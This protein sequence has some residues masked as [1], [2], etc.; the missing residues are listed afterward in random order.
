[1]N[2]R[3]R[4]KRLTGEGKPPG[5]REDDRIGDLRR[6][7]D[8]ILS[9][10]PEP[11]KPHRPVFPESGPTLEDLLP[12]REETTAWGPFFSVEAVAGAKTLHGTRALGELAGVNME[13]LS[14]LAGVPSL[15]GFTP[16]DGLFLDTE[17]T[18]LS[19]GTGTVAF[20]VGAGWFDGR[21]FRTLQLF[22]RDFGEERAVLAFLRELAGDKK[23]LVTFNGKVFDLGILSAR[24]ILN[25]FADPLISL[26]HLD[27]LHPS[28]R[29]FRH[30]L[31]SCR[32]SSLE[33]AILRFHREGDV[34]GWEI[35]Q[36]YF[37][38]LRRR[39]GRLVADIFEHNRLDILS[40]AALTIHFSRLLG[41]EAPGGEHHPGDCLAAARL[42]QDR[43]RV[44]E[45]QAVLEGIVAGNGD[46]AGEAKR[47]LSLL[48]KRNA[49][50]DEAVRLWQEMVDENPGDLFAAEE[51][52]KCFEHRLKDFGQA[53]NLVERALAGA[54]REA[55]PAL[56]RRL[57]R[58]ARKEGQKPLS[59]S[60]T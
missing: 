31:E 30:R 28:R 34:P 43:R 17:T 55:R 26:P 8:A 25:R 2:T 52:A 14:L 33:A 56:H 9:R 51:L 1:M 15:A 20:L 41:E 3:D 18:G 12:G 6:R 57:E 7:I 19:G 44:P 37:D 27:L 4:L 42:F 58:L 59:E 48:H 32:L 35:P 13:R 16:R 38:W 21:D 40:M 50:W 36:R 23:F 29:I 53:R 54:S 24:F 47:R 49:R 10:K 22:A 45:A 11:M 46:A 60:G 39:D 5:E